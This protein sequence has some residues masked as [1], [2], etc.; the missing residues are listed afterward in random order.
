MVS[1]L[2]WIEMISIAC[3]IHRMRLSP[4]PF[5]RIASGR[6]TI[7]VRIQD[8]K[9]RL[10]GKGDKIEFT[11]R[12]DTTQKCRVTITELMEYKNFKDLY[13]ADAPEKFGG[14]DIKSLLHAIYE[15]YSKEE[16]GKWGVVGIRVM[17]LD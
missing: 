2:F 13:S 10:L 6:Q 8:E 12:T 1:L 4:I 9:R 3:M 14:E 11:L 5:E 15:Y 7:E 16:E 17:L